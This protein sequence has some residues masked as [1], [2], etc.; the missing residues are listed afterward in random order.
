M[1]GFT[2]HLSAS[3]IT[4]KAASAP[5]VVH[6]HLRITRRGRAV[7]SV[8][9][10]APIVALALWF[11]LNSGTAAADGPGAARAV[12]LQHVTVA[13]GDSLW[14]IAQIIAPHEDP[15]VVVSDLIDV[16]ALQSSEVTPGQTLAVPPQ[17]SH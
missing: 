13:Q 9:V 12:G 1:S 4:P 6:S 5:A 11:G 17:Y 15:R 2:V 10:A 16:N 14:Q 3:A 8:V 7:L